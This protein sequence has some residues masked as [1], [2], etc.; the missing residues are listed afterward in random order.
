ME[1][2]RGTTSHHANPWFALDKNGEANEDH[3]E[4]YYGAL[5]YSG[6]WK[7]VVEKDD[8][9]R[10]KVSSG[11]ND[12]DFEWCLKPGT[13]FT[14]P[15]LIAGYSVNGL[16][17]AS[18]NLHSYELKYVLPE[19]NRGNLRKILYNSWEATTFNVNEE[20][21]AKLAEIAASIGVELFVM[22]DGWFGARNDDTAGLG[23]WQVNKDKFPNGL[24]GLIDKVN[25]LHMDFGLW[26][27]PEMVNPNSDLYR[28][29][30]DW[31][32]HFP[33]R[34]R[35]EMRNQLVLNMGR[36]DVREFVFS[37]MDKLLSENNIK[38]IKWDMNRSISEPG[39][40]SAPPEEQR[41]IWY[42]HVE[43]IY[44]VVKKAEREAS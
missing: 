43:G 15:K 24:K 11:I 13:I 25:S 10:I 40:P 37:F 29:H 12:F 19:K 4:V 33:T 44:G 32:Y 21:Q 38:F 30:P 39:Y 26:V 35:T 28:K 8:F 31:V 27:E 41:Q 23:D 2:R 18:R 1:S 5:A 20:G 9:N 34:H 16:G 7:I 6:N 14:T 36:D 17:A 42:E 3:G 22:D